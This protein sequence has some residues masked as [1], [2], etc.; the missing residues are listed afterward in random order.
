MSAKPEPGVGKTILVV[1][2][3]LSLQKVFCTALE[4]EGFDTISAV[5]GPAAVAMLPTLVADLI[6]L[7]LMLPNLSGLKVLEAIRADSRLKDLPVLALS[8]A[9]LPEIAAKS[10]LA[11]ATIGLTKSECSPARLVEAVREL[12]KVSKANATNTPSSKPVDEEAR[13]SGKRHHNSKEP[14]TAKCRAKKAGFGGYVDCLAEQSQN[15]SYALPFANGFLCRHPE[16]LQIALRTSGV[17]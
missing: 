10:R 11:G 15:C 9:Y 17:K 14:D 1:E 8:N 3:E 2:D 16:N 12:L 6:V 5:D 7:D 4:R 13:P